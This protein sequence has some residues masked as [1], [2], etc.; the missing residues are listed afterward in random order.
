MLLSI[1]TT[2]T[3]CTCVGCGLQIH[4][5]PEGMELLGDAVSGY[6]G[7]GGLPVVAGESICCA[8]HS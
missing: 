3:F 1:V 5:I 8:E 7:A 2:C 6:H 4:I